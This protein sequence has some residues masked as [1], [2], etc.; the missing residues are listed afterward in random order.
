[1]VNGLDVAKSIMPGNEVLEA[2]AAEAQERFS[3]LSVAAQT[4]M[5]S[6][7]VAEYVAGGPFYTKAWQECKEMTGDEIILALRQLC[8]WRSTL[9]PVCAS[10]CLMRRTATPGSSL[11]LLE[12]SWRPV[13]DM[14]HL[15]SC[16]SQTVVRD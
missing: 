14:T 15:P 10:R 9:R 2:M 1:M 4:K 7:A 3:A 11:C 8:L 13:A 6:D 12:M 16:S 5:L